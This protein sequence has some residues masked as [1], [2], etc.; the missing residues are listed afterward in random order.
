LRW[1]WLFVVV[2]SE[3]RNPIH[4]Q[5]LWGKLVEIADRPY[6][7]IEKNQATAA[8]FS[9]PELQQVTK[10]EAQID[11]QPAIKY[12]TYGKAKTYSEAGKV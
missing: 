6:P 12:Q 4:N 10:C 9:H 2:L 11:Q 8:L 7:K 3:N 5:N 1:L